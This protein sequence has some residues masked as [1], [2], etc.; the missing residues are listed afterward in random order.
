MNVT[1][2]QNLP[3]SLP[4][5]QAATTQGRAPVQGQRAPEPVQETEQLHA[6]QQDRFEESPEVAGQWAAQAA[7]AG[8][9][10]GAHP[11]ELSQMEQ[12]PSLT[13]AKGSGAKGWSQQTPVLRQ[14][15][16]T[17]CGATAAAMLV[18]ANG[19]GQG[20]TDAQLVQSLESRYSDSKG[21]TPDQMG[22][23]LAGQGF[24]VTRGAANFDRDALNAALDSGKKAVAMVDSNLIQPGASG[25][26]PAG[27]A[28]WVE[29]DGK[30]AQGQYRIHDPA[31]GDKYD[32]DLQHLTQAMNSGWDSFHGGGMLIVNPQGGDAGALAAANANHSATL[33]D[34]SGIGS[35]NNSFGSRESGS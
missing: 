5:E 14:T 12:V 26:T 29:I 35:K 4:P 30:N 22:Q 8:Q 21:T 11:L 24:E 33:G 15:D 34:S 27:S 13:D 20:Q 18:R 25:N 17:N 2:P 1:R 32:V 3:P 31:T 23:M 28:H 7:G 6:L 19:G 16:A 10:L 9:P